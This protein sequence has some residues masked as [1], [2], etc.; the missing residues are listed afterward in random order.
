MLLA[1]SLGLPGILAIQVLPAIRGRLVRHQ[2][3]VPQDRRATL[4]QRERPGR[5]AILVTHLQ[6]P[7]R[8]AI[9]DTQGTLAIPERLVM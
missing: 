5:P 1:M 2:K 3:P 9:P 7:A 6:S 8:L 4:G